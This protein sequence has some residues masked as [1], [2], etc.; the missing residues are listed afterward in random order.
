MSP[1]R[2]NRT[3]MEAIREIEAGLKSLSRGLRR[4]AGA[5]AP[6]SVANGKAAPRRRISAAL[7]LQGRYMGLIRTLPGRKKARVKA[8]RA[9]KGVH[10]AIR[11]AREYRA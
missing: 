9:S 11:L 1:R 3:S 2:Q 4:L 10:E 8:I 5:S 6:L 7:R